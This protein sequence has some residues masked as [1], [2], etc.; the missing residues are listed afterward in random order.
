MSRYRDNAGKFNETNTV[1]LGLSVDSI[2]ANM[3]FAKAL[4]ADFPI[5]SDFKKEVARKYGIL[6][7][8]SGVARRTTFVVDMDGVVQ[9]IDQGS[10][11]LDPSGAVGACSRLKK[12]D[13]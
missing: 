11:A 9:H 12:P 4:G 13:A 7:E 3:A 5:L 6:D 2:W 8:N 1:I 10:A